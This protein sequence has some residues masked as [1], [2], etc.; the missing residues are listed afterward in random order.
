MIRQWRDEQKL[1][2]L[3]TSRGTFSARIAMIDYFEFSEHEQ[4]YCEDLYAQYL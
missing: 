2:K 3:R 4:K 1:T